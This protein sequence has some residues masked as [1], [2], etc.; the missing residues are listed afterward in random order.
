MQIEKHMMEQQI[1]E[2]TSDLIEVERELSISQTNSPAPS[3]AS[4]G[5]NKRDLDDAV[6]IEKLRREH[7]WMM[8]VRPSHKTQYHMFV[9][10]EIC[11]E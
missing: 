11:A 3:S 5:S 8:Q 4:H 2:T 1:Q 6:V 7:D 9:T 10:N